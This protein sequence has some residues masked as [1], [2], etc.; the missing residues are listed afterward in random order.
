MTDS[1]SLK[2]AEKWKNDIDSKVFLSDGKPIP[3]LLMAN[4]S[5]KLKGHTLDRQLLDDFC[6]EKGFIGWY[7]CFFLSFKTTAEHNHIHSS[8]PM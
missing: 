5:D 6:K 1:D 8:C 4:K 3:V 7:G 2:G